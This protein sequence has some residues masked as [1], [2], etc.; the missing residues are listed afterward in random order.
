M[1]EVEIVDFDLMWPFANTIPLSTYM[2]SFFLKNQVI[3]KEN[4][5]E[6]NTMR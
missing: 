1:N 3:P 6:I 2:M 4:T 5:M